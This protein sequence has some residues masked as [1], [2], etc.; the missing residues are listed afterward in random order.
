MD[1][2]CREC[3]VSCEG[4]ATVTCAGPCGA[5]FHRDCVGETGASARWTCPSCA[6]KVV[7]CALCGEFELEVREF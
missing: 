7:R 3:E 4:E 6:L 2:V 1:N 5:T